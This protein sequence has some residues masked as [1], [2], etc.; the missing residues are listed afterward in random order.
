MNA[1]AFSCISRAWCPMK[2][3]TMGPAPKILT[4]ASREKVSTAPSPSEAS[5]MRPSICV[6]SA[7]VPGVMVKVVVVVAGS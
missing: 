1:T 6:L 7:M 3:S 5:A 4:R 2:R